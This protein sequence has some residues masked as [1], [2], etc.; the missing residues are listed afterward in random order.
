M[1]PGGS[2][3]Q[4]VAERKCCSRY[5]LNDSRS[6]PCRV[7]V[8]TLQTCERKDSVSPHRCLWKSSL[9]GTTWCLPFRESC[10]RCSHEFVNWP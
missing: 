1:I 9:S 3:G 5:P 2:W 8:S 4:G 10:G 7:E 6:F